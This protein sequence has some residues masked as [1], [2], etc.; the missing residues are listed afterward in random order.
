MR[1]IV[2]F[3]GV[4]VR[5]AVGARMR[6]FPP[7]F[8]AARRATPPSGRAAIAPAAA[9]GGRLASRRPGATGE[10]P[11]ISRGYAG[12]ATRVGPKQITANS[13]N[14]NRN[15]QLSTDATPGKHSE[16]SPKEQ[17]AQ[18]DECE[19]AAEPAAT[20]AVASHGS[21]NRLNGKCKIISWNVNGLR[22]CSKKG[23]IAQLLSTHP[24]IDF[25][26]LQE[27]RIETLRLLPR[28]DVLMLR[29]YF[30]FA[31][32]H[33]GTRKGYSGTAVLSRWGPPVSLYTDFGED[34]DL[35]QANLHDAIA[36]GT[37]GKA[38]DAVV[39]AGETVTAPVEATSATTAPGTAAANAA[40]T[41]VAAV[42]KVAVSSGTGAVPATSVAASSEVSS[43]LSPL[44]LR[45]RSPGVVCGSLLI[46]R[47]QRRTASPRAACRPTTSSWTFR[48]S[49]KL[50]HSPGLQK[51]KMTATRTAR[52]FSADATARKRKQRGTHKPRHA[53]QTE[54]YIHCKPSCT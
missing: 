13:F 41:A 46:R 54:L 10:L 42:T 26:C 31:F 35:V 40:R 37:I 17:R 53:L 34:G 28:R 51:L 12:G 24:D 8:L 25:L 6:G 44:P 14:G 39:A 23:G 50:G 18:A 32:F 45:L 43:P 7:V 30:P 47:P 27:T 29:S 16:P 21:M 48:T 9:A 15:A 20:Q 49:H 3:A 52:P 22:A 36:D 38:A 1:K 11:A 4:C 5:P 2:P 33:S 19:A